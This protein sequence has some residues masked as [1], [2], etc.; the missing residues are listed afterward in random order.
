MRRLVTLVTLI[1][2]GAILWSAVPTVLPS[3]GTEGEAVSVESVPGTLVVDFVDDADVEDIEDLGNR[4][5]IELHWTHEVSIDERLMRAEVDDLAE[6]IAKLAGHPLVEVVEPAI[7]LS[8]LGFPN[9]PLYDAQWNMRMVGAEPGWRAGGGGGVVV[10]VIDTGVSEVEDLPASR[11]LEG[12]TFV[13][14]TSDARDDHGHGTHVAGTIAQAT[15]N[16]VGVTGVA[17]QATILRYKALARQGFGSSDWVAAAIDDAVDRGADVIN[18]SLGGGHSEVVHKAAT[19][20][21]DAGVVVVAAV[22]NTGQQGVQCPGHVE[23][24]VGVASVGPD[25]DR[26]WYS[27]YGNGVDLAAPG[28]DLRQDGGG[29]LQDT[30]DGSGGHAYRAFQGTSMATPHVAGAAAVLVGMGVDALAVVDTLQRTAAGHVSTPDPERGYGRL[31]LR[32]AVAHVLLRQRGL[33]FL[34]GGVLAGALG[35]TARLR[36]G[37]LVTI[38]AAGALSAGG[39][40]VLPFVPGLPPHPVLDLLSR[41]IVAWPAALVGAEWVHFPLWISALLPA[42]LAFALGPSRTLGPAI[43][44]LCV[45]WGTALL[46]GAAS[47]TLDPWWLG[48][49]LDKIWLSLNGTICLLGAMAVV[50]MQKLRGREEAG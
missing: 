2:S 35:W 41:G 17:P 19:A 8:A 27:T 40:F 12:A 26:A 38:A 7:Q 31:D 29:V 13:P 14:G 44:G 45:G 11:I 23:A 5:G 33:L 34:L 43:A 3:T 10:A 50:G 24:V 4:L 47:G 16:G 37:A 15:H 28:G 32:A 6:A 22:G 21:A 48:L 1:A 39:L 36:A 20:A 30:I 18:M 9:D 42:S 49:G 46:H 25:D